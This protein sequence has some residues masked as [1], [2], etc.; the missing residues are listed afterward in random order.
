MIYLFLREL[1]CVCGVGYGRGIKYVLFVNRL[2][3]VFEV[4]RLNIG[5]VVML[6]IVVR[7]KLLGKK[8]KWM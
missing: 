3:I 6:C 7:C 4:I 8:V 2:S 5:E 1:F